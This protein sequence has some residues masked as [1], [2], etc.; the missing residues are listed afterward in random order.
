M[1]DMRKEK[2]ECFK[3]CYRL[4]VADASYFEKLKALEEECGYSKDSEKYK[5]KLDEI[6]AEIKESRTIIISFIKSSEDLY[7]M[8]EE[9]QRVRFYNLKPDGTVSMQGSQIKN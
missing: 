9:G 3:L 2:L 4:K 6:I 8:F 7:E 1:E 5:K